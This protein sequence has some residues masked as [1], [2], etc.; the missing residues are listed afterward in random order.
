MLRNQR[1]VSQILK[2]MIACGLIVLILKF[3]VLRVVEEQAMPKF[4]ELS[5]LMMKAETDNFKRRL[6]VMDV[7]RKYN[8]GTYEET[9]RPASFKHPPAP[10]YSVFYIT[11][12]HNLSYCPI[13]K[14]GSTTWIY[15]LCL[16]MDVPEEQLNNGREQISVVARR[17]IP[18]L[19]YPE[20]DE[21]RI[22]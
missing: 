14:A 18:E 4:E 8:L 5:K 1:R 11:R 12:S 16:L 6:M 3:T 7:C 17:A 19:E 20:A 22:S 9:D 10:Q 15:N 21:R 2:C 13:Y